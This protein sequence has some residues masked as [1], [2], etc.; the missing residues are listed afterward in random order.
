MVAMRI[1]MDQRDR[2]RGKRET[3]CKIYSRNDCLKHFK[4]VSDVNRLLD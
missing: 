2:Q 3:A 1:R 4:D